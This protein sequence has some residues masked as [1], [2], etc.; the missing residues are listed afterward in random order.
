MDVALNAAQADD[1]QPIDVLAFPPSSLELQRRRAFEARRWRELERRARVALFLGVGMFLAWVVDVGAA[2]E[3]TS[4]GGSALFGVISVPLAL[5]V[6]LAHFYAQWA[7]ERS[8]RGFAEIGRLYSDV[9]VREAAPL[10]ALARE[11]AAIA[12]Y[13]RCVG[14]QPRPLLCLERIAL[15]AWSEKGAAGGSLPAAQ[16]DPPG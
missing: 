10:L 2:F 11:H 1:E 16:R 5:I 8:A 12:Q 6:L 9:T 13:L 14:R 15:Y 3:V 4:D 7:L